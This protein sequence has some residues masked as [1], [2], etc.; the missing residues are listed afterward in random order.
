MKNLFLKVLYSTGHSASPI[1]F[2]LAF[3]A[4]LYGLSGLFP[5]AGFI[6]ACCCIGCGRLAAASLRL[7]L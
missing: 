4:L 1:A 5:Q 6:T 7:E 3:G 2:L